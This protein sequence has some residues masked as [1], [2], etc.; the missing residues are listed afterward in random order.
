MLN[1]I[2]LDSDS[3]HEDAAP[4]PDDAR[5]NR[6]SLV[7]CNWIQTSNTRIGTSIALVGSMYHI[8]VPK[9]ASLMRKGKLVHRKQRTM[10]EAAE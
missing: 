8:S 2:G 5:R 10:D 3:G 1:F 9:K 6:V 4:A 7:T